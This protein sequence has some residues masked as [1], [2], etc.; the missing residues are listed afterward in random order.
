M[1][2]EKTN[3]AGTTL[4]NVL[5]LLRKRQ[6]KW[7]RGCFFVGI[8]TAVI[9]R[10]IIHKTTMVEYFFFVISNSL[11]SLLHRYSFVKNEK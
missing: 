5:T 11:Q 1:L 7:S 4:L 6:K 2:K 8:K 10:P 3:N 9:F